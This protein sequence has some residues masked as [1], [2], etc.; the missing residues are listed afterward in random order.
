MKHSSSRILTTHAGSLPRPNDLIELFLAKA[1]GAIGDDRAIRQRLTSAV[2][3][4]VDKQK[5]LG[6]DVPDDGEFGKATSESVDYAPWLT[7]VFPRLN[8][9]SGKVSFT[10]SFRK[11]S[12][13]I[14]FP[15]M[16]ER[17]DFEKFNEFYKDPKANECAN[18]AAVAVPACTGPVSYAGRDA[19]ATDI[20]NLKAAMSAGGID[21]A[22]MCAAS[23]GVIERFPNSY[24]PKDEEFLYAIA[25]AMREEYKAIVD[26]G[27]V[28]QID[29]PGMPDTWDQANPEP[30]LELYRKFAQ[31]RIE[32]L[33]HALRGL[34][35]DRIRYH[36]C[37]GSWHGPH[38]TDIPLK[39]VADL[40]LTVHAAA[41]SVEAG[42]VRHEHE[43]RLWQSVK[44]PK[45]KLL[46]PGVVSHATN[47]VEHP[48]LV[49]ERIVR[50]AKLVGRENVIAGTDCGLGGR[51]HPLIA[52]AK[53]QALTDG[54]ALA[55][56][57]LWP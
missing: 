12:G 41:Y 20:K 5:Q 30:P 54:A 24:Y 14:T 7:Y 42:N 32:A 46:I 27:I 53:L 6:V 45:D 44:L 57:Q 52:W 22:F 1:T 19:V 28:L 8:G 34:P 43:W 33:N 36:I 47:V 26:A 49:A 16:M 18:L 35:E 11:V 48:E 15:G 4:I 38:T 3:E 51:I 17:R 23:P 13:G 29:D 10:E 9:F 31:I 37:W 21:E 39:D 40:M 25:D 2:A 55:T 50:L 56:K